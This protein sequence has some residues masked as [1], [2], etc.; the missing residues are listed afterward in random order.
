MD[1]DVS[2]LVWTPPIKSGER[3]KKFGCG[4]NDPKLALLARNLISPRYSVRTGYRYLFLK[5]R[6]AQLFK[7]RLL[8][9]S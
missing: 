4:P 6:Q 1:I 7:T 9:A 5:A 3:D 8:F 2:G